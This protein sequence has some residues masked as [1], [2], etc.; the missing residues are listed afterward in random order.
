[1]DCFKLIER[2]NKDLNRINKNFLW[3]SN[4]GSNDKEI[5][6]IYW[7]EVCRPNLKKV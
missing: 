7:E 3:L 4:L 5:P 2:N 1:M 6:L